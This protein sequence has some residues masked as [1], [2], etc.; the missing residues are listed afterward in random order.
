MINVSD[1]IFNPLLGVLFKLDLD[2]VVNFRGEMAKF[3]REWLNEEFTL[4]LANVLSM[5]VLFDGVDG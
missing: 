3:V 2:R 5:L 4:W 1:D